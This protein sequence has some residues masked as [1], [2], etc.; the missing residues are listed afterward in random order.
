MAT[1]IIRDSKV[2]KMGEYAENTLRYAGKLMQ[3]ID[4]MQNGGGEEMGE[5]TYPYNRYGM[6]SRYG[7]RHDGYD[8]YDRDDDDRYMGMRTYVPGHY[9]Y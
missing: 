6:R 2:N 7:M 1:F 3:C 4:E 9:R 8:G 5:R